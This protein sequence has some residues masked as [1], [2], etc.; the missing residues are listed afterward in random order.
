MMVQDLVL[1]VLHQV[2][3]AHP[4][5]VIFLYTD[6]FFAQLGVHCGLGKGNDLALVVASCR[7]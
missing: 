7:A 5:K 4:L 1:E 6:F 3:L 2:I